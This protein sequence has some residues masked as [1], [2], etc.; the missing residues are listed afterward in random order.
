[1]SQS[2]TLPC[3]SSLKNRIAKSAMSENMASVDHQANELFVKAYDRWAQGGAGLLISGNVMVDSRYLGEPKNVVIEKGR[4]GLLNL[5]KWAAAGTLN[6][7]HLWMQINHPGKQSPK[8]L[9]RKPVAPSAVPFQSSLAKLFNTPRELAHEEIEEII[10]RFTYAAVTA[11]EAGFTGVQIHGAH[12]YLVSQ[13][14]SPLHN[15]RTD[16]WGGSLENRMRFV[17]RIYQSMRKAVG[18]YFPIGIKLNSADFQKGGFTEEDSV[19]VAQ[20]LSEAGIDLIEISGG[21]YEAPKM[22]GA[23][24]AGV[25]ETTI[26]R[27]AYFLEY[28]EKVRSRVSCPILLTGG[29]RTFFGMEQ[30]LEAKACCLIGLARSLALNPIF[31]SQ[32]LSGESAVSEVKPLS[33]G[34]KS[35]DKVVPLEIIWYT[36]QIHRM[37]RGM[38]PS[39]QLSPLVLA[40]TSAW[41][42]GIQSLFRVRN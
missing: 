37:G 9:S 6:N 17:M 34:L 12:G 11:Q 16:V 25:K 40:I 10:E 14:L 32:L 39:P 20:R 5:K 24:A 19:Q 33:T 4:E 13:F 38:N 41:D 28:C 35:L 15:Q 3:G 21:T 36:Q 18:P 2:L 30:A 29:F 42:M 23:P 27:E 26:Q 31:P 7:T 22:T 1:M 8:F